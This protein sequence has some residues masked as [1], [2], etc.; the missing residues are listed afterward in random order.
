M[1][2]VMICCMINSNSIGVKKIPTERANRYY[3]ASHIH[4]YRESQFALIDSHQKKILIVRRILTARCNPGKWT[5]ASARLSIRE[6]YPSAV[7]RGLEGMFGLSL[8]TTGGC[9]E[10]GNHLFIKNSSRVFVRF[11]IVYLK[12]SNFRLLNKDRFIDYKWITLNELTRQR[13]DFSEMTTY[14]IS[15]IE[16]NSLQTWFQ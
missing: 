12:S 1:Y 2:N 9:G 15:N 10:Y 7:G 6:D 4:F 5:F 14:W 3:S 11:F 16:W 13:E 8:S